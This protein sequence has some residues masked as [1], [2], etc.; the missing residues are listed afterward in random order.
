[1]DTIYNLGNYLH[2]IAATALLMKIWVCQDCSGL[3]GQTQLL[4]AI[5]YTTRYLDLFDG[6]FISYENSVCK[7]MYLTLGYC[8]VLSIY[9]F[10][11]KSYERQYDTFRTEI[12]ISACMIIALLIN[13][14]FETIEVFWTFS[15]YLDAVALLPQFHFISKAG[16]VH[17]HVFWYITALGL[18][19]ALYICHWVYRYMHTNEFD[20]L[21]VASGLIQFLL[22][23]DFFTRVLP[24]SKKHE[25]NSS[26]IEANDEG[27]DNQRGSTE[28]E[29]SNNNSQLKYN[30]S[31]IVLTPAT[32]MDT[33]NNDK[34]NLL[35]AEE[36]MAKY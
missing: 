21:S 12:L 31:T 28:Q 25:S 36:A 18:Y 24:Y 17:K 20:K 9:G 13:Y 14:T 15:M 34:V 6:R 29:A 1:M 7:I 5:I 23:L 27:I 11:R 32:L 26:D 4:M 35:K 10:F 2:L 33:N 16:H 8:T 19:R 3:S 22:Y 30:I